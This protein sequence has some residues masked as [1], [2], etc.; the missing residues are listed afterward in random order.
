MATKKRKTAAPAKRRAAAPK[1][2]VLPKLAKGEVYVGITLHDDK[3]HHLILLPGSTKTAWKAAGEWAK[4]QGGVLPSRHDGL[5]LLK[6]ARALFERAYHWLD[7]QLAVD[8]S[9]AWLQ[10]FGWGT[11]FNIDLE[12]ELRVRAVRRVPVGEE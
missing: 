5:V 8:S 9:Y 6:H 2:P 11:Q 1:K 7:E 3:L 4:A 10:S 12:G